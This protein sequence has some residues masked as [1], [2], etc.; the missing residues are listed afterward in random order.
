MALGV[1]GK[2]LLAVSAVAAMTIVAGVVSWLFYARMERQLVGLL[3]SNIPS[4]S[5]ALKLAE[6][7]SRYA[8]GAPAL[9]GARN[10]VQRQNVDIALKQQAIFIRDLMR[11]LRSREERGSITLDSIGELIRRLEA[12]LIR[13]NLMTERRIVLERRH[14]GLTA[15]I[16][17]ASRELATTLR[18]ERHT[19]EPYGGAVSP[20]TA[21]AAA[22]AATVSRLYEIAGAETLEALDRRRGEALGDL[23]DM[24]LAANMIGEDAENLAAVVGWGEDLLRRLAET[25]DETLRLRDALADSVA[26]SG[27][28]AGK[29]SNAVAQ[30]VDEVEAAS[31][32][33]R[34]Q[35]AAELA[36]AR[37]SMAGVAALTFL[38]PVAFVWVLIGRRIVAPLTALAASARAVAEGD[39]SA[40]IP[41][42]G[43]DEIGQMA[44]ALT[45]FRDAAAQLAERT[46][47]LAASE[48]RLRSI[49]DASVYPIL[50]V[51]IETGAVLFLNDLAGKLFRP[52]DCDSPF[53]DPDAWSALKDELWPSGQAYNLELSIRRP[54]PDDSG[55]A[56]FWALA[57]AVTM[58]YQNAPAALVSFLDITERKEAERQLRQA[59]DEAQAALESL[60]MAQQQLIQSEKM[61][62]L[63]QLVAGVAHEINTPLGIALTSASYLS[64]ETAKLAAAAGEGRMRRAD[65]DRYMANAQETSQLL[66]M[67][68]TRA[69]DLVHS[70]KQ[71]SAD[72]TS[73]G[74]RVFDLKHYLEDVL[75][76]LKPSWKKAGHT[77]SLRC[78]D[79]LL[80]DGYPGALS[81]I[82]ANLLVNA[83]VHAYDEGRSGEITVS[84]RPV[85]A[86]HVELT[87]A[88]DGKGVPA[89]TQSKIFDPFFTTRRGTGST[90]L[91]LN[92]VYNLVT[93]H[94]GG[95]IRLESAEGRG[96]RFIIALPRIAPERVAPEPAAPE[97]AAP[98]RSPAS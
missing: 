89:A 26:V 35:A 16:D 14:R 49:L 37:L 62:S 68:V 97:P 47:E 44:D 61:A 45:A 98:D 66:V 75:L 27:D 52:I 24:P 6:A 50:I 46:A 42:L 25:Q 67:N 21:V 39:M 87:F 22:T 96:A 11:A 32:T 40:P 53:P 77:V 72:Q 48:A 64:D 28:V 8:A 10:N 34:T 43:R 38:G 5:L 15:E 92:I 3:D 58:T 88:D 69:A 79:D 57:S 81:Q 95:G 30:F 23:H 74:R 70:F 9:N 18:R 33:V 63:G 41:R 78:P 55:G 36:A 59:R 56:M 91:G 94:L 85:G 71:V 20:Q 13:L 82:I 76:S 2:L 83:L 73:D 93:L 51:H 29:L 80:I 12:E 54:R 60:R 84:V 7:S 19:S 4:I 1:R 31:E 86:D 90:G 65:F 17:A